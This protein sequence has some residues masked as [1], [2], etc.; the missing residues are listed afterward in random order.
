MEPTIDAIGISPDGNNM[1]TVTT[2][3][4]IKVITKSK[5]N[6]WFQSKKSK[7]ENR[8]TVTLYNKGEHVR[9]IAASWTSGMILASYSDRSFLL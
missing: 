1:Y 6:S 4:T 9:H 8:R 3:G 7:T 2:Q 5:T